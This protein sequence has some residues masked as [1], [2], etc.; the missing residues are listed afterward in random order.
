LGKIL[1]G[2]A[3]YTEASDTLTEA[4]RQFL[5][6]GDVLDAAQCLQSLGYVLRMEGKYTEALDTWTD[7]R[8]QLLEI[9][10]VT[11]ATDSS[12][13]LDDVRMRAKIKLK[14]L[15]DTLRALF[16]VC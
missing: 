4:R 8:R 5:E 3:K 1:Y 7:A 9:G 6:I 11:G 12:E 15:T 2:Q 14:A 13:R 10:D 16:T